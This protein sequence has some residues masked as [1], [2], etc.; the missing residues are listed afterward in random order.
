VPF[1]R[2]LWDYPLNRLLL[3]VGIALQ[4]WLLHQPPALTEKERQRIT[5]R[6]ADYF[7]LDQ[8][9]QDGLL[10]NYKV[11]FDRHGSIRT[12]HLIPTGKVRRTPGVKMLRKLFFARR[13]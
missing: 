11:R 1:S 10:R 3:R 12:I 13:K 5:R 6:I 2:D 4:S 9:I 7:E 8:A